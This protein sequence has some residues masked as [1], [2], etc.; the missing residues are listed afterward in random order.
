[1]ISSEILIQEKKEYCFPAVVEM[2]LKFY[3]Y[4]NMDQCAIAKELCKLTHQ[5]L[6]SFIQDGLQIRPGILNRFFVENGFS[7]RENYIS[8]TKI[9]DEYDFECKVEEQ[10]EQKS[11]IICGYNYSWLYFKCGGSA[12]HVSIICSIN[13]RAGMIT[14]CDP[15]HEN[16]GY[17]E[18]KIDDLWYALKVAHAGI[19]CVQSSK[20]TK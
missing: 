15:G 6:T 9:Y 18:V 17:K 8:Y 20:D 19:W 11:F 1:M 3:G 16:Y 7:L 14:L 4:N 12:N 2:L 10:I 13:S 5:S